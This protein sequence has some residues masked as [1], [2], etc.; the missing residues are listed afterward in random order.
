[1]LSAGE[2]RSGKRDRELVD[3]KELN[4]FLPFKHVFGFHKTE[5]GKDSKE[6]IK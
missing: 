4:T 2:P 1:M 5:I 3:N 6:Q